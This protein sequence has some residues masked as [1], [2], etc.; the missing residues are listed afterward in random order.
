M[1]EELLLKNWELVVGLEIHAQV[2]LHTKLFSNSGTEF[3]SE[4]NSQVTFIDAGFPGM[5]PVVNKKAIDAAV[6]TGLA[7]GAKIN[8]KSVFERKHYFYP[9]LPMG[10]QISQYLEP[11]V[12]GGSVSINTGTEGEKIINLT[13][14]H[15]END[16]G[17]SI[18]DQSDTYSF[19]DLNRSG[20]ALMEIVTEPELTSP[21]EAVQFVEKMRTILRYL[22]TS[23]ADM[24]KGSLRV[25]VNVSVKKVDNK[26]LGTRVEIKNLN[27]LKSLEKAIIY[28]VKRQTEILEEGGRI[29]Q[30]TRL[31]NVDTLATSILRKKEDADDYRYFPDPDLLPICLT[32]EDINEY[33]KNI[34]ELPDQKLLRYIKELNLSQYDAKIL[35]L[36]NKVA[37][38]FEN[39]I[40]KT[41]KLAAN[42]IMTE[43]F[44][45]MKS[46][47]IKID[48][49][50][51]TPLH[52]KN[53]IA[54]I[55]DKVISNKIAKE[56]FS[57]MLKTGKEAKDIMKE[58]DI[59]EISNPEE[60][61]KIILEVIEKN[62]SQREQYKQGKDKLLMF[63]VG[64]VMKLTKGKANPEMVNNLLKKLL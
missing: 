22:N 40:Y 42:W 8:K 52:L 14:I 46:N 49:L 41:P 39:S 5:L 16:A 56:V 51:I 35:S 62:P 63:F 27:S 59:S 18:H 23:D 4:P 24:E 45:Y 34:P 28:E 13:R 61:E 57:L 43:I 20:I 64:Q 25:D 6:L 3:G 29:D 19:I 11:I 9:D 15:L 12:L 54:L 50:K 37:N 26:K 48:Q 58:L 21:E 31:F 17:K 38:F 44:G 55:E 10:Y 32:E 47:N 60:I 30:E 53:L 33:K 2:K 1:K 36:D 7:V